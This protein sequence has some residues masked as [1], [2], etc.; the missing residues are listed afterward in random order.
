M[1]T[2]LDN[3]NRLID[4]ADGVFGVWDYVLFAIMLSISCFIGVFLACKDA[5][6]EKTQTA[7]K[8]LLGG[9]NMSALPVAIS[10]TASFMSSITIIGTPSE[11]Y[12]FGIMFLWFLVTYMISG[13]LV[14]FTLLPLFYNLGVTS[15]YEYLE[16]RFNVWARRILTIVYILNTIMYCDIVIA[17]TTVVCIFYTTLGG[18]KAVIWTDVFQYV[19][20]YIGFVSILSFAATPDQFGRFQNIWEIAVNGSRKNF[21]EF[22]P[23]PRIRHS[24]WTIIFG[25]TFGLWGGTYGI[26][27]TEVQRY[28]ACK[29]EKTA[30]N[31]VFINIVFICLINL[32]A[33]LVGLTMYAY[34]ENCDPVTAGWVNRWDQ[35]TPYL[36]VDTLLQFPGVCGLY[37]ASAF[38]GTLSTASSGMN[39]CST[40]LVQDFIRPFTSY[41]ERTYT[42]I[43]KVVAFVFGVLIMAFAFI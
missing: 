39:G 23:D 31:A 5:R 32:V 36:T 6:A 28:L 27:Q 43:S 30:R 40:V 13:V 10:L 20:M 34:Y 22:D 41:K 14:S 19:F 26:N 33:G 12:R 2:M 24:F 9:R 4:Y 35:L 11:F 29:S 17:V 8:Y 25:G 42:L 15:T 21:I 18:L 38:A 37:M 7:T 1:G 3:E 16:M